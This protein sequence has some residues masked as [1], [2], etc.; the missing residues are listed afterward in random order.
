ML[1]LD[2]LRA[3]H[4]LATHGSVSAAADAMHVTTSAV[5][6]QLAKLE[7]E[8]GQKLLER[9]GRGVRLTDAAELLV[10]HADRILSLV[11]LAQ[12]DLEA[13]RGA[14]VGDLSI[15]SFPTAIRGL[16]PAAL[17]ELGARHPGLRVQLK[18]LDPSVS[19]PL[20][21]RG[22]LDVAIVHD[23]NNKRL[24]VPEGL[25]K[26]AIC[27][28]IADVAIPGGHPLADRDEVELKEL[29]GDVW[30][31]STPESSC[32]DWLTATIRSF[33]S[34]PHIDH[35]AYEFAT[36]LA[37]VDAGLGNAILPRLGR[38]DVPDT[39]RIVRVTPTLI[40]RVYLLWREEA[41]RRPAI[42]AALEAL[43]SAC[44]E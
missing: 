43:R 6:Q 25:H 11:E 40:R 4:A 2:R 16:M 23:W 3:L 30:I 8:T 18:E 22:D 9:H 27:E 41:A 14:V 28:D 10:S 24:P 39:V 33:D 34:E 5:S 31:S 1:D 35:M 21:L 26:G 42:R 38:C 12:A 15:G 17:G 13:H 44:A 7:R 37:L 19:V 29:A 36:Q 32:H 20:V